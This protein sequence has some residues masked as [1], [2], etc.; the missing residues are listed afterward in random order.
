MAKARSIGSSLMTICQLKRLISGLLLLIFPTRLA[1]PVVNALG[2]LIAPGARVGFSLLLC[3]QLILSP[4]ARVGHLN[5]VKIRRVRLREHAKLGHMNICRG[6]MSFRLEQYSMIGN[7][8]TIL[9]APEGATYGPAQL[10]LGRLAKIT[11]KHHLDCTLSIRLGDFS[12][13]AGSGSQVWTHGYVHAEEGPK[14]YRVD[15]S[16]IIGR[17]VYLGSSIVVTGGVKISDGVS[18]GVGTCVTKHLTKP[19]FYISG[20]LRMLPKP[21]DPDSRVD[22]E[23]VSNESLVE[24][25]YKRRDAST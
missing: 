13:L 11:A 17:N 20:A 16:V 7:R 22:L 8:N 3:D 18:V 12:T 15:G 1:R 4:G 25:V 14:R 19:G 5:F 9:R 6:P 21:V 2:N 10:W 23:R 24:T